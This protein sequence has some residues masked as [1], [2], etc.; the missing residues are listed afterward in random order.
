M[1]IAALKFDD[2]HP[3]VEGGRQIESDRVLVKTLM[4]LDLSPMDLKVIGS[5]PRSS[6]STVAYDHGSICGGAA[7][8]LIE[9]QHNVEF[10]M[11]RDINLIVQ[12]D[13]SRQIDA[14]TAS[15]K[16]LSDFPSQFEAVHRFGVI[17]PTARITRGDGTQVLIEVEI[18]DVEAW[19][20]RQ[21]YDLNNKRNARVQVPISGGRTAY[22]LSPVW[23]LREKIVTQYRRAA[24]RRELI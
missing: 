24:K 21:Q 5:V 10:R 12:P 11:T 9:D 17:I 6:G 8:A 1:D 18:F 20:A 15:E 22:V 4:L 16:L 13:K 23:L 14:E 3:N 19:P 7:I 2:L